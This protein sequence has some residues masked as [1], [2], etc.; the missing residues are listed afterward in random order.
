MAEDFET[1]LY[2]EMAVKIKEGMSAFSIL[3]NVSEEDRESAARALN[4]EVLPNEKN[5]LN[6]ADDCLRRIRAHRMETAI[7]GI[8]ARLEGAQG[9]DRR[10]LMTQLMK[11]TQELDRVK[12]LG[13]SGPFEQG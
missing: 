12:T 1:A 3:D 13:R 6:V 9:D 5:A 2:A 7:E 8:Q 11:L 4:D 10:E